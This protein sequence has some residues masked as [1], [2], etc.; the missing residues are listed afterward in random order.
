MQHH[1]KSISTFIGAKDYKVSRQ[2]YTDLGFEELII[3]EKMSYFRI[4]D[5]GFYLQ[6]YYV[7][8]WID[9]SMVFL[10]VDDAHRYYQ[11]LKS[12]HLVE[13]YEHVKLSKVVTN[14]WG[15][16]CF[17]HDPAGILWHFG[18]FNS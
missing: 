5:F 2:F 8:D 3:S 12:L 17:L 4:G 9:N 14:D 13:K 18:H 10:E 11:E 7:K 15:D 6:D 16:E 1:P